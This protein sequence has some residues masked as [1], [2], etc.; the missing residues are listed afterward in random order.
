MVVASILFAGQSWG[1]ETAPGIYRPE[2]RLA[3]GDGT[4]TKRPQIQLADGDGT[5]TK[6]PQ[7]Q[8]ADGDGTTT[9]R[10]QIQLADGDGTTTK[11]PQ[12]QLADRA[13]PAARHLLTANV[14]IHTEF[15]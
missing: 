6:R 7:I 14:A 1:V 12:V 11:R 8:L 9:K 3:D 4:T 5:T 2:L 15:V 13:T 10:P